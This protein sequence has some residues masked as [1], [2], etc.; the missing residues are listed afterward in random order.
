MIVFVLSVSLQSLLISKLNK[1]GILKKIVTEISIL[2][3]V[4]V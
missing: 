1:N 4:N 3:W 2:R